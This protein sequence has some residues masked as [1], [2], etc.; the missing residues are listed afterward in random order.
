[1]RPLDCWGRGFEARWRLGY[2][3]LLIFVCFTGSG[4]CDEL[5]ADL[6]QAYRMCAFHFVWS[7]V[8]ITLYLQWDTFYR[9]NGYVFWYLRDWFLSLD[10]MNVPSDDMKIP[11][12][13]IWARLVHVL[14]FLGWGA[15]V[16]TPKLRQVLLWSDFILILR[17]AAF[18][19][20]PLPHQ[21]HLSLGYILAGFPEF[22][23]RKRAPFLPLGV[24]YRRHLT[25]VLTKQR[26][27]I[28]ER[29]NVMQATAPVNRRIFL[30]VGVCLWEL[31]QAVGTRTWFFWFKQLVF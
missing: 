17:T 3:S 19:R 13:Y 9:E 24:L 26:N 2:L 28:I 29:S 12:E 10:A 22:Y 25:F 27:F 8:S 18:H 21:H 7:S 31:W 6:E 20:N 1:M 14:Y 15:V 5:I 23:S 16:V 30:V 4:L 11:L